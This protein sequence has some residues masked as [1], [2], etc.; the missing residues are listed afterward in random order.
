MKIEVIENENSRI[1]K[2]LSTKLLE[3]SRNKIQKLIEE[4]NV[5]VNDK[6]ITSS[7][8]VSVGDVISVIDT[9]EHLSVFP[10][11]KLY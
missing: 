8:K 10:N 1:D 7:Y 4:G 5:L 3:F 9:K 2:Y 6:V 11:Q